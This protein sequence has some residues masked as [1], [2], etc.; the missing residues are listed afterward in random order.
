MN[1]RV[2]AYDN[3]ATMAG[4]PTGVQQRIKDINPNAKFVPCSNHSLILVCVHAASVK[5]NSVTFFDTLERCYSFF[6]STSTYR[7]EVL[8]S[9]GKCLKRIQNTCWSTRGDAVNYIRHHYKETN[10]TG[11][12]DGNE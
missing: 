5:I 2:K 11:K 3:A 9:T 4:C 1:C 7:W 10:C 12:T 8:E 6:F